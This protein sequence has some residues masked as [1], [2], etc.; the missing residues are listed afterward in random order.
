MLLT[1]STDIKTCPECNSP[2]RDIKRYGR[3]T[4]KYTLDAQNKKFLLKYYYQL[5]EIRKQINS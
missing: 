1:S 2:I 4:K 5:D 3:I